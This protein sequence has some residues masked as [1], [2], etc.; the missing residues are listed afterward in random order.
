MGG[1]VKGLLNA[2]GLVPDSPDMTPVADATKASSAL[3]AKTAADQLTF[4]KEQY[5]DQK[6]LVDA[7]GKQALTTA[8]Q[9][10]QIAKESAA[11]SATAWQQNQDATQGAVG[12]MGLNA[13]GAQYLNPDQ[14]QRLI[15]LQQVLANSSASPQDRAAAQAETAQLQKTAESSGIGL[16]QAKA[17][18]VRSTAAGQG[19][20]VTD[21][22]GKNADT[23]AQI[24]GE[25]AR[26][27]GD[28][29]GR[30]AS[31]VQ[32]IGAADANTTLANSDVIQ[33]NL[34]GL[35]D[36]RRADQTGFYNAQGQKVRDV[37]AQRAADFERDATTQTNADIANSADQSQRQ[38]LRL[39]GD[40]NRLAALSA[41]IAQGQQLARIGSG[42]QVERTN[43]ANLNAADDQARALETTGF[44]QGTDQQYGLQNQAVSVK[45][46][47]LDA[48]R[49]TRT[50]ANQTALGITSDAAK[51]GLSTVASTSQQ[52]ADKRLTGTTAG[53]SLTF[54][55]ENAAT[56]INNSAKEKVDANLNNLQTGAANFGAGFANTSGATAQTA[57]TAGTAGSNTLST[58]VGTGNSLTSTTL[59]G[60]QG[61][62]QAAQIQNQG[63]LGLAAANTNQYNAESN[64]IK[65]GIGDVA[66]IVGTMKSTRKA[67]KN[68]TSVS[69]DE[70]L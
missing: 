13:L 4:A 33:G 41:E 31:G 6:P 12:Q 22:Y 39:G 42:N 18:S 1:I 60:M 5:A 51:E 49:A 3:A 38:L 62:F 15:Q 9:D 16:E 21:A 70:A 7:L 2:V 35:G 26:G 65:N 36:A 8:Q 59:G 43:I 54:A 56:N 58:A 55:G 34:N 46:S 48:A 24:G 11:R 47:A 63:A 61:V 29:A 25:V 14:T 17:N 28:I 40:P 45:S 37:A 67:K 52:A 68:I 20:A 32:G 50:Q 66:S 53:Q 30:T 64:A 69:D 23:T 19:A 27:L 44:Q 57:V 10:Q